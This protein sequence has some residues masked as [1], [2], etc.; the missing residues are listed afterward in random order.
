MIDEWNGWTWTC[1][2]CDHL[3]RKA[4]QKEIEKHEKAMNKIYKQALKP[5]G[6]APA[7]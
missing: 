4:T 7:A 2:Q 5:T 6:K 1:F 3:G